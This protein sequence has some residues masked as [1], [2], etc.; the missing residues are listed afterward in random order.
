MFWSHQIKIPTVSCASR[1]YSEFCLLQQIN[2]SVTPKYPSH[3]SKCR[4]QKLYEIGSPF[5]ICFHSDI[6]NPELWKHFYSLQ[7]ALH[8]ALFSLPETV[9]VHRLRGMSQRK[10]MSKMVF[11]VNLWWHSS[12]TIPCIE[13]SPLLGRCFRDDMDAFLKR[14]N[15]TTSKFHQVFLAAQCSWRIR[16]TKI[17]ITKLCDIYSSIHNLWFSSKLPLN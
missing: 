10:S 13:S 11:I 8:I 3:Q 15:D 12:Q 4:E 9:A 1:L 14:S 6:V 7:K 17:Y 16:I 2:K 5:F